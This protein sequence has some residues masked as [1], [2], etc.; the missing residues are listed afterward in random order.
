MFFNVFLALLLIALGVV[1]AGG[2]V[3]GFGFLQRGKARQDRELVTMKAETNEVRHRA[4]MR[5]ISQSR[6]LDAL[7]GKQLT[8]RS[9]ASDDEEVA[10]I[11][12]GDVEEPADKPAHWA[13]PEPEDAEIELAQ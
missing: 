12:K 13:D 1:V 5:G 11:G 2:V 8:V 4:R 10:F 7:A 3:V 9:S 6:E